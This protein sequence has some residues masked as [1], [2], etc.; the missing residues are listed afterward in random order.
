MIYTVIYG[1]NFSNSRTKSLSSTR[2]ATCKPF[3]LVWSWFA[4]YKPFGLLSVFKSEF[5]IFSQIVVS[6]CCRCSARRGLYPVIPSGH[7]HITATGHWLQ[8]SIS[9][10]A[11]DW[12]ISDF[13]IIFLKTDFCPKLQIEFCW[14]DAGAEMDIRG[15]VRVN[16]TQNQ[17]YLYEI[18]S[19]VSV[20]KWLFKPLNSGV[21]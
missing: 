12:R 13:N 18:W 15:D 7:W 4:T 9:S 1:A 16:I 17:N 8:C 11:R 10:A 5:D 14:A 19:L 2:V 21:T 3:G 6:A 20:R